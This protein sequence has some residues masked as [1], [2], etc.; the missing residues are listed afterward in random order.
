M[1]RSDAR[2]VLCT[3]PFSLIGAAFLLFVCIAC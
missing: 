3:L 1:T 2:F